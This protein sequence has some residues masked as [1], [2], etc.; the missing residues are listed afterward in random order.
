MTRI[1]IAIAGTVAALAATVLLLSGL[2]RAPA[3]S[4]GTRLLDQAP[5]HGSH[6]LSDRFATRTESRERANQSR[7]S[8]S[9][10]VGA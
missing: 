9:K 2:L 6:R 7:P 10:E 3:P 1:R 8:T 5:R 4:G